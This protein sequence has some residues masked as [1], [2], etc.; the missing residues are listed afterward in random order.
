MNANTTA[1]P[2]G[3]TAKNKKGEGGIRTSVSVKKT[4]YM[5]SVRGEKKKREIMTD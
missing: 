2:S 4:S 3:P 1:L 5:S